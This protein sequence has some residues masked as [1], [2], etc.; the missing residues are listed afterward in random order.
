M[1]ELGTVERLEQ[2][3]AEGKIRFLG[4]SFHDDYDAFEEII[5]YRDWDFCQIQL[6]YMD[7]EEQA[8]M[9]GYKLAEELGIPLTIMEPV[10]GGSLAKLSDDIMD[11]F[12]RYIIPAAYEGVGACHAHQGYGAAGA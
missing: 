3:K 5:K 9:K 1:V 10:K 11:I 7:T 6:N 12:G 8:G 4:F 2:L